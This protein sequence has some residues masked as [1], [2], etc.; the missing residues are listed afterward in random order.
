[1]FTAMLQDA[2]YHSEDGICIIYHTDGKLHNQCHLKAVTKVK[3]TVIRDFLFTDDCALNATSEQ[4]M[5]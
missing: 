2:F 1:M 3:Q 5:H 4:N